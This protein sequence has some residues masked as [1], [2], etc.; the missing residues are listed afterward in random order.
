M[1][2]LEG[3]LPMLDGVKPGENSPRSR[4]SFALCLRVYG[5]NFSG[6]FLGEPRMWGTTRFHL[7]TAIARIKLI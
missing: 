1:G 5:V 2:N 4:S 3:G 6:V 7:P